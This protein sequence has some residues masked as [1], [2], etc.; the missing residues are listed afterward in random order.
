MSHMDK[1]RE[2]LNDFKIVCPIEY[3]QIFDWYPCSQTEIIVVLDDGTKIRYDAIFKTSR[4]VYRPGQ[5]ESTPRNEGE[6]R[7]EFS[8]RLRKKLYLSGMNSTSLSVQT[9]ISTVT[10]SKYISGRA[11]PSAYNLAKIARVLRC[12]ISELAEF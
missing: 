7:K 4:C 12:S 9:N 10:V 8:T 2:M 1:W 3:E 5:D 6:W 11:S